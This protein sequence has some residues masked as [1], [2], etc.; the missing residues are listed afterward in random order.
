MNDLCV[1]VCT[2]VCVPPPSYCEPILSKRQKAHLDLVGWK[3]GLLHRALLVNWRLL[4]V[5]RATLLPPSS[6]SS[7]CLDIHMSSL[8]QSAQLSKYLK[9]CKLIIRL[10]TPPCLLLYK[11][12][13]REWPKRWRET[14]THKRSWHEWVLSEQ[15]APTPEQLLLIINYLPPHEQASTS[16]CAERERQERGDSALYHSH[17]RNW[18]VSQLDSRMLHLPRA[19]WITWILLRST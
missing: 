19:E 3:V 18:T 8:P 1:C 2:G 11:H 15:A 12:R 17:S 6:Q 16:R 7:L 14:H 10:N 5:S 4:P 9:L 13:K